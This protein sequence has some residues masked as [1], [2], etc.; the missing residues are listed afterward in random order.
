MKVV[1]LSALR[2]GRLNPPPRKYSW[3][4]FL[5][6]AESTP[7]PQCGR[8]DYVNVSNTIGNWTRDL[9]T[10]SAVPQP[11]APPRTPTPYKP[12]TKNILSYDQP[13]VNVSNIISTNYHIK[14][15][16]IIHNSHKTILLHIAPKLTARYI[17]DFDK[18]AQN[19]QFLQPHLWYLSYVCLLYFILLYILYFNILY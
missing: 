7:G 11:T 2:T 1:R 17:H 4:S 18:A 14:T 19:T 5:L 10:C 15:P 9:P 3:Y 12:S 16:Y 13:D 8:K 6:E